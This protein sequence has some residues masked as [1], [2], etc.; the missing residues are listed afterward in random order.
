M[1]HHSNNSLAMPIILP[2]PFTNQLPTKF[3][4]STTNLKSLTPK[5]IENGL[6][7]CVN[8][9]HPTVQ[10]RT[11]PCFHK[12]S[13]C[14]HHCIFGFHNSVEIVELSLMSDYQQLFL[15]LPV[16]DQLPQSVFGLPTASAYHR[17]IPT[18]FCGHSSACDP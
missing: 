2:N 6:L 3:L 9:A 4:I 16:S 14:D 8:L 1:Q 17:Q 10:V 13:S 5:L 18:Y 7:F 15:S 11:S 12:L